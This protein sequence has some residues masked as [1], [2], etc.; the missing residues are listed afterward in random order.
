MIEEARKR[1]QLMGL[2]N[3]DW[4]VGD[5]FPLPFATASF[6]AVIT[7]FSFHHFLKP[8]E[9]FAE[10]VRGCRPTGRVLMADV[11]MSTEEQSEVFNRMEGLRDPSHTRAL[12]L[13]ELTALLHDAGLRDVQAK[14]YRLEVELERL[15]TAS[16][17]KPD[18]ATIVRHMVEGDIGVNQAWRWSIS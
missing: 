1:Q 8:Q 6:S 17:T 18:D 14:L 3:M 2:T 7:R 12:L 9:V 11:F 5:V 15:L 16:C 10:M 13:T 4:K